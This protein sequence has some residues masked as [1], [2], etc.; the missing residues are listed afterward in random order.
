MDYGSISTALHYI[1]KEGSMYCQL[2]TPC[3]A[4]ELFRSMNRDLGEPLSAT[5]ALIGLEY[6]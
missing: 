6:R 1:V 5:L 2:E 3:G 4:A